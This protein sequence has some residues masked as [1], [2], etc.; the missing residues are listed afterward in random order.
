[1]APVFWASNVAP[2]TAS[3]YA[4][5]GAGTG[6]VTRIDV[7]TT[8][9]PTPIFSD[10]MLNVPGNAVYTMFMLGDASA[11]IHLLQRDH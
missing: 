10:S 7:L 1:M 11:P 8:S 9:N 4:V 5:V 3:P 2:N 6:T